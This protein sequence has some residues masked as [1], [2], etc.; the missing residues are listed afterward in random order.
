MFKKLI[1]LVFLYYPLTCAAIA[2]PIFPKID[3]VDASLADALQ[4]LCRQAGLDLVISSDQQNIKKITIHLKNTSAEEAI[5]NILITNGLT[6]EKKG[7]TLLVSTMPQD[8][9]QTGYKKS[10]HQI[11]LKY[12]SAEKVVAILNKIMPELSVVS[13]ERAAHMV[14]RGKESD[15]KEASEIISKIDKPIPQ[16]LIEGQIVEISKNDSIRIGLDYNNG[17]IKFVN[18]KRDDIKGTLNALLAEGKANIIA[19][20]RIATLDNHEASINIGN[21]IPYAVPVSSSGSSTQ[22][23]VEYIQAG[24]K[25][26]ITPRIGKDNQIVSILEPEV[27]SISEWKTTAAGEFPV[28][29]S[30][31]ASATLRTNNGET[32]IVGGLDSETERVNISRIP[33]IGQFP[34]LNLFFQNRTLEKS[35]TEIVFLITPHII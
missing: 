19:S 31:N 23:T 27:S 11:E 28:I 29:S 6:S 1:F 35:K 15:I 2:G 24:V 17:I 25:L 34:I 32:I 12:L 21:R 4:A 22:W 5:D 26:K 8:L 3:F 20:P 18:S 16:I 7:K 10:S 33:I 14:L 13:C 30:R 9:N